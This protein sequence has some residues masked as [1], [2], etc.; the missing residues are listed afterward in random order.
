MLKLVSQM[1]DKLDAVT[2]FRD[3]YVGT[4]EDSDFPPFWKVQNGCTPSVGED[5]AEVSPTQSNRCPLSSFPD[6]YSWLTDLY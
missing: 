2:W 6:L 1:G 4:P 5:N 3:V